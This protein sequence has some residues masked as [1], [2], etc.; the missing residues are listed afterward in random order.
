MEFKGRLSVSLMSCFLAFFFLAELK[1]LV[2]SIHHCW[3]FLMFPSVLMR[4]HHGWSQGSQFLSPLL[5]TRPRFPQSCSI[6]MS[7]LSFLLMM[8]RIILKTPVL[9][10]VLTLVR[11]HFFRQPHRI[12]FDGPWFE[13]IKYYND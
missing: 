1:F 6:Q 2:F 3:S 7:E 5:W 8:Y 13:I 4:N 9:C 10:Q 12:C 11:I